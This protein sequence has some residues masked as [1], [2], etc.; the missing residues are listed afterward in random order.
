MTQIEWQGNPMAPQAAVID[1]YLP[2]EREIHIPVNFPDF[3]K[4]SIFT[5]FEVV[6]L[7]VLTLLEDFWATVHGVSYLISNVAV[8]EFDDKAS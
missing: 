8:L 6:F 1:I 7:K 2:C 5:N 4:K 3:A